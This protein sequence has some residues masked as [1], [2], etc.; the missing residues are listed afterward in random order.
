MYSSAGD[1]QGLHQHRGNS[2][3][4]PDLKNMLHTILHDIHNLPA[5]QRAAAMTLRHVLKMVRRY[6]AT[7]LKQAHV[8]T[9]RDQDVINTYMKEH[10]TIVRII[11]H[12]TTTR[13]YDIKT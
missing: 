10:M 4:C 13:H 5:P 6:D 8:I 2:G 3:M 9:T 1:W 7:S 12:D 11:Y